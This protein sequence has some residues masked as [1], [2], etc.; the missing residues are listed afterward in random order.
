MRQFGN[1]DIIQE[2]DN[3]LLICQILSM[4]RHSYPY[5][6]YTSARDTSHIIDLLHVVSLFVQCMRVKNLYIA[7][8]FVKMR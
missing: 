2:F 3:D 5:D 7:R 4:H 1:T 8:N 6:V